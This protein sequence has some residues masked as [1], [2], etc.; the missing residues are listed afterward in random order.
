MAEKLPQ[1][2]VVGGGAGGR[3]VLSGLGEYPVDLAGVVNMSDDGGST[4]RLREEY[5]VMPPGDVRQ[6]VA[7]LSRAPQSVVDAFEWRFPV[8][9]PM[10]GHTVGNLQ[11]A[12]LETATGDFEQALDVVSKRMQ[13]D[14]R[15]I[16]VTLTP[17]TLTLETV[18][19]TVISGEYKIGQSELVPAEDKPELWLEPPAPINPE[20]EMAIAEADMVVIA[21]GDLYGS[22]VPALLARGMRDALAQ[23]Q[24][25]VVYVSN[26]VNKPNQTAGFCSLDYVAELE[27]HLGAKFI[28]TVIYNNQPMTDEFLA[29]FGKP[30]EAATLPCSSLDE[31][32]YRMVGADLVSRNVRIARPDGMIVR[33]HVRHDPAKLAAAILSTLHA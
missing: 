7:A 19:G 4:G 23:T 29:K 9:T 30:G 27:H 17:H 8:G 22:L 15:V 25:Q 3:A 13:V 1:I 12:M 18:T 31:A 32:R 5:G 2:T 21:P 28:D 33:S 16:P 26:L 24:A 11:L 10:A 14:G 6:A 20:A